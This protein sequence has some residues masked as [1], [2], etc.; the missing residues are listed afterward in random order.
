[1]A[2]TNITVADVFLNV[3]KVFKTIVL[4]KEEIKGHKREV[5]ALNK[6]TNCQWIKKHDLTIY[7]Q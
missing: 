5:N 2:E 3:C 6:R 1:M 4:Q 7:C